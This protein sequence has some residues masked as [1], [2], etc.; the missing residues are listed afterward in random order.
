MNPT[1]AQTTKSRSATYAAIVS[2]V[3]DDGNQSRRR[4]CN[5]DMVTVPF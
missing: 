2:N 4:R 1:I 5:E 3:A